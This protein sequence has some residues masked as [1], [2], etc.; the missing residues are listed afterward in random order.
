MEY[1]GKMSVETTKVT[2]MNVSLPA[3][4][5]RFVRAR[6]ESGRYSSV[7]EVVR[8]ALRLL[9]SQGD[10]PS[11]PRS[12][13]PLRA[14]SGAPYDRARAI[15]AIRRIREIASKS[16]LGEFDIERALHEGHEV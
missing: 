6:V 2:T 11:R 4:L 13:T 14:L 3:E 8:E 7:S 1:N 9:A 5:T 16:S 15:E 10:E 12:I